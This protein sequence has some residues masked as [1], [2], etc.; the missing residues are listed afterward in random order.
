VR[1]V[2]FCAEEGQYR[3]GRSVSGTGRRGSAVYV[4]SLGT[5]ERSRLLAM[6]NMD[7]VGAGPTKLDIGDMSDSGQAPAKRCLSIARNLRVPYEFDQF[8][9]KSDYR[10]FHDAGLPI[11]A[12]AWG[13]DPSHHT[14]ADKVSIIDPD[15]LQ[16]TLDVVAGYIAEVE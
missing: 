2:F 5:S 10:P 7:M 14:P 9:G 1:M 16:Q 11:I 6:V 15:K 8:G 3:A 4:K 12:L 13:D